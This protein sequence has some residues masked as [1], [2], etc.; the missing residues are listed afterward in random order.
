M[1]YF[2][3]ITAALSSFVWVTSIASFGEI[4]TWVM[5]LLA[6]FPDTRIA[7]YVGPVFLVLLTVLFYEYRV[8]HVALDGIQQLQRVERQI[9]LRGQLGA[10]VNADLG[11]IDFQVGQFPLPDEVVGKMVQ[12]VQIKAPCGQGNQHPIAF[13]G[14]RLFLGLVNPVF[15]LHFGEGQQGTVAAI[16]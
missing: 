7:L 13:V 11:R 10:K 1:S 9:E 6:Y 15:Q 3:V 12:L 5:I 16:P 14:A 4:W 8:G 2:V